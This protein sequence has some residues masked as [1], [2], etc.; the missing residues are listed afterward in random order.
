MTATFYPKS[1]RDITLKPKASRSYEIGTEFHF[2]ENR[3]KFDLAYYNKLDYDLQT[4]ARMSYASGFETTLINYGEQQLSRGFEFSVSGDI[5]KSKDFDWNSTL[6]FAADRYYYH[7]IDEEYSTKKPW[8][9]DGSDWWWMEMYDWE[10]DPNGNLIL[11]NGMPRRS[12]YPTLAGSSNP[13]WIWGWM[14]SFRYK[15]VRLAFSLDGRVGGKMFN[16]LE[17]RLWH[18]GRNVD[19]DNQWRYDEVVN[20]KRN[21]VAEGVKIVSGSVKYDSD[22]NITEDTRVFAPNDVQVSYE[23]FIRSYMGTTST[24]NFLQSKSFF[25]L[26]ELS[27]GYTIPQS[28]CKSLK[29]ANADVALIG[30][31][32]FIWSKDFRFSDP[33]VDTE[34]I[35]SPSI[36]YIGFNIKLN[37]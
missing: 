2:F 5:F 20:G 35:N 23:S 15:N 11:Y 18:S 13:D 7:K 33:D 8:I 22:G 34:N 21:Y 12:N 10:T 9:K 16:Y 29:I 24:S 37:F 19:S 27:I 36:R 17:S 3:L 6:N 25:K 26:R 32:L 4:Q 14:N 30:Q 28:I 1:I 31:N